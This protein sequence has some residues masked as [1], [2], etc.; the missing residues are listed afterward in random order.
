MLA[1]T[2]L[3]AAVQLGAHVLAVLDGA[4]LGAQGGVLAQGGAALAPQLQAVLQ[5]GVHGARVRVL[6]LALQ[7]AE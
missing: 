7:A 4:L 3:V 5:V 6:G 1:A 2:P